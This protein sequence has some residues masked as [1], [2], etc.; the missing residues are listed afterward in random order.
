MA[1]DRNRV[2]VES[3]E[4]IDKPDFEA[5]QMGAHLAVRYAIRGLTF[6]SATP[7]AVLSTWDLSASGAELTV[8]PGRALAGEVMSDATIEHGHIV[9][10]DGD[11]SQIIDFTGEPAGDYNIYVRA[12]FTPGVSGSRYFWNSASSAEDAAA[13]DTREVSG[14]RAAAATS[15][16][17]NEYTQVGRAVWDGA[18]FTSV[19]NRGD[20]FWE[21]QLGPAGEENANVWGGGANDRD[22]DRAAYGVQ[23]LYMAMALIRRQLKD[24]IGAADGHWGSAVPADLTE[25]RDHIDTTTDPHSDSPTWTGEPVFDGGFD[26][27]GVGDFTGTG[28][29]LFA[30]K[31]DVA[32]NNT[33]NG[34]YFVPAA[35]AQMF[36]TA[37]SFN[38]SSFV[39][40]GI[41]KLNTDGTSGFNLVIPIHI[42]VGSTLTT[43]TAYGYWNNQTGAA[44]ELNLTVYAGSST[45]ISELGS[46]TEDDTTVS[47]SG[48]AFGAAVVS[49]IDHARTVGNNFFAFVTL[50]NNGETDKLAF[51]GLKASYTYDHVVG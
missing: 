16:P 27:N 19:N 13:I 20:H 14:W 46:A 45:I 50:S 18:A 8:T 47:G 10:E 26:C 25:T 42:P 35:G 5:L 36:V 40:G 17:G 23:S 3:N 39:D 24:I 38:A 44:A 31:E 51:I 6:G 49:S 4:R 48:A 30:E 37:G 32:F 28:S 15:S 43:V 21:G 12:D 7:R 29:A 34:S 1:L 22:N 11:S 41:Y 9:G 33:Q 2:R